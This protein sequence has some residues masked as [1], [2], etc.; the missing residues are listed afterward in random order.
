MTYT[1]G[2]PLLSFNNRLLPKMYS[3]AT[4]MLLCTYVVQIAQIYQTA[5]GLTTC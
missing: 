2:M 3:L 1:M 5:L 4:N